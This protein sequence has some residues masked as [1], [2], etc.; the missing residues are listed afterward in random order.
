MHC[1]YP[2]KN[3]HEKINLKNIIGAFRKAA[4]DRFAS[5][6]VREEEKKRP[7]EGE[8]WKS[9]EPAFWV[10]THLCKI[11][12]FSRFSPVPLHRKSMNQ[13]MTIVTVR[14]FRANIKKFIDLAEGGEKVV[15]RRGAA[16]FYLM[17]VQPAD[18]AFSQDMQERINAASRQIIDMVNSE[19]EDPRQ[20]YLDF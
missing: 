2:Y 15:I 16:Q 13:D 4:R 7:L 20:M 12:C 1:I 5:S 17:P 14:E 11:S 8:G 3:I 19:D 9:F 6:K 18:L 10:C